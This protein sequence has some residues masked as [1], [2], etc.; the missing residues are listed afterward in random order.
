MRRC[1]NS[2]GRW[3]KPSGYEDLLTYQSLSWGL[4]HEDQLGVVDKFK[5]AVTMIFKRKSV[6]MGMPRMSHLSDAMRSL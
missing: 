6:V 5:K 1:I 3:R 2:S 4:R